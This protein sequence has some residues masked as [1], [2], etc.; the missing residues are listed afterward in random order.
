MAGKVQNRRFFGHTY[1]HSTHN[2]CKV[3]GSNLTCRDD[4]ISRWWLH[5]VSPTSMGLSSLGQN[6]I[7]S[8]VARV[9][10]E[11]V[12]NHAIWH[13]RGSLNKN[14]SFSL[15]SHIHFQADLTS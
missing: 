12:P 5:S 15:L 2:Y 11:N 8:P 9:V 14:A 13:L 10:G 7:H 6:I 1:T 4:G 3:A